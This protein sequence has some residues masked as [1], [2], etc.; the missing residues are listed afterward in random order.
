MLKQY[1]REFYKIGELLQALATEK[2]DSDLTDLSKGGDAE[3]LTVYLRNLADDCREVGLDMAVVAIERIIAKL[4]PRFSQLTPL[5]PD[6]QKRI[7]DQLDQTW[8]L[9]VSKDAAK[10]YDAKALFGEEVSNKFPDTIVDIEE[11]GKCFATARY[12]A[13]VFHLMRVMELTVQHLGRLLKVKIPEEKNWQNI[14]D[15]IN[16]R[17]RKM[18]P[19][20]ARQ[21]ELRDNYSA[22]AAHLHN[23]KEAWRNRVMHPKATYTEEEAADVFAQV[24]IFITHAAKKLPSI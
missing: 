11:A 22:S 15:E 10:Y 16:S 9:Y 3:A 8:F 6:I 13:S 7:E 5:L 24:K 18:R 4:P 21:K 2:T 23:V 12:T 20:T 19:R 14:L 1:A 17:I